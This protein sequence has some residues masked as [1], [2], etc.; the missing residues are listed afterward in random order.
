MHGRRRRQLRRSVYLPILL[1]LSLVALIL[2]KAWT[3]RLIS[4]V[5]VLVPFQHATA[6][7]ADSFGEALDESTETVS[8]E[9]FQALERERS[10]LAHQVGALATRVSELEQDIDVLTAT[11]R[12]GVGGR[13]LGTQGSLIPAR[14]IADD[15]LSWRSSRLINAGA[16]QGVGRGA[17]VTS[18]S[19]NF[20]INRGKQEGLRDGL[21][22]LLREVVL[23][24][25]EQVGTHTARVK[26][27]SDVDVEMKV[28][29][30]RLSSN[31]FEVQDAYYWLIGR[32]HGTM[33]IRDVDRRLIA[34]QR[35]RVGDTVLSDPH[36]ELLPAAMSIGTITVVQPDR[37]NPLL[38]I[39]TVQSGVDA[40]SLRRVY[41]FDPATP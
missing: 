32:G 27:L 31:G 19:F 22:L 30:G 39:L 36:S 16:L 41:V 9:L 18:Q 35:I 25:V 14:I 4:L 34:E 24:F 7:L 2:P 21:S 5:Q 40:R 15:F 8:G 3:G 26:L 10:A 17:V 13:R 12:W 38:S 1:A 20:K 23:G 28:K 37:D 33:Q 6:A 11:R 29:I